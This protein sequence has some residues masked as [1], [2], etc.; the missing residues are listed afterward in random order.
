MLNFLMG[1]PEISACAR[2]STVYLPE[3]SQGGCSAS[4]H[5]KHYVHTGEAFSWSPSTQCLCTS[6]TG[7]GIYSVII[8]DPA[9]NV[10]SSRADNNT[11]VSLQ[12]VI[13]IQSPV[14]EV[15]AMKTLVDRSLRICRQQSPISTEAYEYTAFGYNGYSEWNIRQITAACGDRESFSAVRSKPCASQTSS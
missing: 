1:S 11:S 6:E 2:S 7:T 4:S 5:C 8:S 10:V 12:T 3:N 15:E 9:H 14:Q 13:C